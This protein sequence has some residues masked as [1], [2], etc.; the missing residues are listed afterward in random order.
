MFNYTRNI[1]TNT[2]GYVYTPPKVQ[3]IVEE[4]NENLTNSKVSTTHME[5]IYDVPDSLTYSEAFKDLR[6]RVGDWGPIFD[7]SKDALDQISGLLQKDLIKGVPHAPNKD[8]LFKAFEKT[9]LSKVRVVIIGQE[10]YSNLSSNGKLMD[11]GLAF[12][13]DSNEKVP[14]STKNIFESIKHDYPDW[15]PPAHGD[16]S[17]W[18]DQ[19]VLLLNTCLTCRF[20]QQESHSKYSVWMPFIYKVFNAISEV[21][22]N[23]I[24]LLWGKKAQSMAEYIGEKSIIME[25]SYPAGYSARLGFLECGH[26]INTNAHLKELKEEEIKW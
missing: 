18:A 15:T 16:L 10:P 21:R 20:G 23:C 8:N 13:V 1:K 25:S 2:T 4:T 6:T 5:P 24:Y 7:N 3:T 12:S 26:F 14:K 11:K 22:P 17:K 19:G 9:Q